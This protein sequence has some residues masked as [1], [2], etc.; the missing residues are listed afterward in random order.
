[1]SKS[2]K[3]YAVRDTRTGKLVS[4]LTNPRRKFW[5]RKCNCE[6]AIRKRARWDGKY[7]ELVEL[8]VIEQPKENE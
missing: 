4:N 7:Y 5:E 3:L 6:E 2:F 1:M 8:N